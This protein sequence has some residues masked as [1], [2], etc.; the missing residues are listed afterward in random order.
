[1]PTFGRPFVKLDHYWELT[2][3]RLWESVI[4]PLVE[5]VDP[6]S[7]VEIGADQAKNTLNL[8]GYA[9]RSS[10][11]VHVIEPE[12][13]FDADE[14]QEQWKEIL[15]FYKENSLTALSKI[16]RMDMVLLDGDHNWY[17]TYNELSLIRENANRTR[18]SF[19]VVL[20][21]DIDW[22]YGRRD[23]YYNPE[24]IPEGYRKP[25]A[26]KGMKPHQSS[27]LENGG[28]NAHLRNALYEG[29]PRNGVLTAVEDFMTESENDNLLKTIP[30]VHGL[31]ILYAKDLLSSNAK[32][33]RWVQAITAA[34]FVWPLL[35][36]VESERISKCIESENRK[37]ALQAI[38][39]QRSV[40]QVV[41][42]FCSRY[43]G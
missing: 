30:A 35:R 15:V 13:K 43:L 28:M 18:G 2:M 10:S 3:H 34:E 40:V 5:I 4:G 8:L 11:V 39:E 36:A 23:L 20:L 14:L 33:A 1:M 6:T 26:K 38:S 16:D 37:R 31:G 32:F 19:P 29:G 7:I 25:Y 22:P 17:T 41:R 42:K 27:L 21:H 12:P 24:E 9:Q